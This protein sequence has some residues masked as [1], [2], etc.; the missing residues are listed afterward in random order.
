MWS[1]RE[2]HSHD[3]GAGWG[4]PQLSTASG[5]LLQ[6]ERGIVFSHQVLLRGVGWA[7]TLGNFNQPIQLKASNIQ[8]WKKKP[9]YCVLVYIW[10]GLPSGFELCSFMDFFPPKILGLCEILQITNRG[11]HLVV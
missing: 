2:R 3:S 7:V 1:W 5:T 8:R 4:Q 11:F 6:V 9:I 10:G